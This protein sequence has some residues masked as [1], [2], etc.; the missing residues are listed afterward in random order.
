MLQDIRERLIG[1]TGKIMLA[2]IL[3]LLAGTGLN[4]TISP[5]P[6]IAKVNGEEITPSRFD[7]AMQEQ[8]GRLGEIDLT[9]ALQQQLQRV[10]LE[11]AVLD[12]VLV[13][14]LTE[15]GYRV[16]DSQI[17]D[18]IRAVPDFQVDGQFDRDTYQRL[19]AQ[20][21]GI[22]AARF[23]ANIRRDLMVAQY[24]GSLRESA[25]MTPGEV[26][27]LIELVNEERELE[28]A[29]VSVDSFLDQVTIEAEAVQAYYD[30]SPTR[31]QTPESAMVDYLLVDPALAQSQVEVSDEALAAYFDE[32]KADYAAEEER[33]A[34]HILL[35]NDEDPAAA[36]ATAQDLLARL[37]AGEA[38]EPL[39]E[40]FSA[41]GGSA[42]QGGDLGWVRRG[43]FVAP[44]EEAIFAMQPG[45]LSDIVQS[46]FG[47]H[48]VRL[49]EVRAGD[50]P[51]LQSVRSEVEQRYRQSQESALLLSLQGEL[52]DQVFSAESL[53]DIATAMGM[54]IRTAAEFTADSPLP[55]GV[56][57]AINAAVFG[58]QALS[59]GQLRDVQL[60]NDRTA[61]IR[62]TART[63]AGRQP[64]EAVAEQIKSTLERE[65]ATTLATQSGQALLDTLLAAPDSAFAEV[66]A[67]SSAQLNEKAFVTRR[68]P[69]VPA[70]VSAAAFDA[71]LL[72]DALYVG[73]VQAPG[74]GFV[75][76]RL[77][78]IKAGDPGQ[79]PAQQLDLT[80]QQLARRSADAQLNALVMALRDEASI[81][82]G[83]MIEFDSEE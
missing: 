72:N 30:D 23:E 49:E 69:E 81:K 77:T 80:R 15:Q 45:E 13:Q 27:E 52:A 78:D 56:N 44:V 32:I 50:P 62:V 1:T 22:T 70:A 36:T 10:A 74:V 58:E 39:A 55:F 66:F 19:V 20:R 6:F 25:F 17:S 35:R 7:A 82:I 54:E 21:L 61:V 53:E 63:P 57:E 40:E 5:A 42:R 68:A 18:A 24:A 73:S 29:S 79:L 4:Y 83:N 12:E 11:Q 38:F 33:R 37:N 41:D 28:F 8:L 16:S 43:D 46:E 51:T 67:D 64:L 47:L 48:I 14:Y 71:V 26:R 31:F 76:Y 9:P 34:R 2:I 65:A 75:I 3:L 60:D 59:E